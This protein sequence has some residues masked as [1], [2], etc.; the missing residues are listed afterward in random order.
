MVWFSEFQVHFRNW[1]ERRKPL[2]RSELVWSLFLSSHHVRLIPYISQSC[3]PFQPIWLC[4]ILY[5]CCNFL[6]EKHWIQ[7]CFREA[8]VC[9]CMICRTVWGENRIYHF[10]ATRGQKNSKTG[11]QSQS[12]DILS[13]Y[14]VNMANM[15]AN[16]RL[17]THPADT[18][19]HYLPTPGV[20]GLLLNTS[21]TP[22]WSRTTPEKNIWLFSC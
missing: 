22:V 1:W 8:R 21:P 7:F 17:F 16:S 12:P 13:F 3:L 5:Q 20:S 15:L 19:Q 10:L 14:E 4:S 11:W 18:E 6:V 9:I 2:K